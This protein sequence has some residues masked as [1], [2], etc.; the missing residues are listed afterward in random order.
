MNDTPAPPAHEDPDGN[1]AAT[2]TTRC[3]RCKELAPVD[4]DGFCERCSRQLEQACL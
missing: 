2:A 1:P 4:D 3:V